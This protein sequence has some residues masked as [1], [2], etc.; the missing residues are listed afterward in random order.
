MPAGEDAWGRRGERE[1]EGVR[2]SGSACAYRRKR[3]GGQRVGGHEQ[4][5]QCG[6]IVR[7]GR[8]SGREGASERAMVSRNMLVVAGESSMGILAA[9]R[10]V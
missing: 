10:Y 4:A 5:A 6:M 1:G 8:R 9:A 2:M 7:C 3:V